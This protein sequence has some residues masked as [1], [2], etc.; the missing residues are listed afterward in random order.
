MKS[1]HNLF[2]PPKSSPGNLYTHKVKFLVD[3]WGGVE[4][5]PYIIHTNGVD[6]IEVHSIEV[7]GGPPVHA[8]V[9]LTYGRLV[10]KRLMAAGWER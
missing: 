2:Y 7:D 8:A 4:V 1:N 3:G 9:G 5:V 6:W 10:W